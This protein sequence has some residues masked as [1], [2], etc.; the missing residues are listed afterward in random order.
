MFLVSVIVERI[1]GAMFFNLKEEALYMHAHT[2][3][4]KII[5]SL[6]TL[7]HLFGDGWGARGDNVFNYFY[8]EELFENY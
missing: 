4:G 3:D 2:S 5:N 6:L 7:R 8:Y 1:E